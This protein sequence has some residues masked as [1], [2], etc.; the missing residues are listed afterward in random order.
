[1]MYAEAWTRSVLFFLQPHHVWFCQ[2]LNTNWLQADVRCFPL[3][4]CMP[5]VLPFVYSICL[6]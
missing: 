4:P 5:S 1:M 2:A 6:S 3:L